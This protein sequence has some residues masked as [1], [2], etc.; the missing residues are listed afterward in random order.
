[1]PG[2]LSRFIHRLRLALFLAWKILKDDFTVHGLYHKEAMVVFW[3]ERGEKEKLC[4][5]LDRIYDF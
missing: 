2:R 5:I 1:V 3:L 4:R